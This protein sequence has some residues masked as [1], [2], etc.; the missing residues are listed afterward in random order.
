MDTVNSGSELCIDAS[1]V[2]SQSGTDI[3]KPL[4]A[5]NKALGGGAFALQQ[6]I[7]GATGL[8]NIGLLV[9]TTGRV[10]TTGSGWFMID[11]GSGVG[12]KVYGTVPSGTPYVSVTGACSCELNTSN[13]VVRVIQSTEID[14]NA[15]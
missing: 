1:N 11:D 4:A 3:I 10:S 2:T 7:Y 9:R 6:G 12:V 13:Q 15:H 5:T 8:N 14:T